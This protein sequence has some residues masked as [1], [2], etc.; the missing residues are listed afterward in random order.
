[1]IRRLLIFWLK[2]HEKDYDFHEKARLCAP[3]VTHCG[4]DL[5]TKVG[6]LN[7]DMKSNSLRL[8]LLANRLE[9]YGYKFT[10]LKKIPITTPTETRDETNVVN[11]NDYRKDES[12]DK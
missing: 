12:V 5:C 11:L 2:R 10:T 1:M 6:C 3:C 9:D 4:K 7:M 8:Q